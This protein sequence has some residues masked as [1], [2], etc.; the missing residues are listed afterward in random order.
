MKNLFILSGLSILFISCASKPDW[1][2]RHYQNNNKAAEANALCNSG[3]IQAALKLG[4]KCIDNKTGHEIRNVSQSNGNV[5]N[6]YIGGYK[7]DPGANMRQPASQQFYNVFKEI[8]NQER[9]DRLN[10]ICTFNGTCQ[11]NA[12]N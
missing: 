4:Y 2:N 9:K 8:Y 1:K 5:S 6:I 7:N 3:Q 10:R 12:S 11:G